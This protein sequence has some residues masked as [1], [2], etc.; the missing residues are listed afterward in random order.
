MP[1]V[2]VQISHGTDDAYIFDNPPTFNDGG[3]SVIAG[4]D[5]DF[6]HNN[7]GFFRWTG[8]TISGRILVAYIEVDRSTPSG[9]GT[10]ELRVYGVKDDNPDAPTTYAEF[11]AD[12][13]TDAYV[14]WD[15]YWNS[16]WNQ[17]PSLVP[18]FQELV[19]TFDISNEAVMVQLWNDHGVTEEDEWNAATTYDTAPLKSAKLHIEYTDRRIFVVTTGGVSW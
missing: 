17:S 1:T 11:V 4:Y 6:S 18:I 19:N 3:S 9:G 12:P 10:P 7:H 14:D 13:L 5:P 16:G 8:V 2:D 15:G